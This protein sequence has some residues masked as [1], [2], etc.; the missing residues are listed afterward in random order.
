MTPHGVRQWMARLGVIGGTA[1]LLAGCPDTPDKLATPG[2]Q[3]SWDSPVAS[4]YVEPQGSFTLDR[5]PAVFD[6]SVADAFGRKEPGAGP[7]YS[8]GGT[9]Y[10]P[11]WDF[12]GFDRNSST[13]PRTPTIA[14][15]DA[16][17]MCDGCDWGFVLGDGA[18]VGAAGYHNPFLNPGYIGNLEPSTTY[19]VALFR[20]GTTINGALDASQSALGQV[21][22]APDALVPVGGT[23]KG[24]P[25][26]PIVSFPTIIPMQTD[27]NPYILGNFTS[28]A[29]GLGAFDVVVDGAGVLY[30]DVSGAPPDAAFDSSLV[31]RNDDTQTTFPRYN[32][33]VILQGPAVDAA[34]A[35][36]NPQILRIQ[37]GQDFLAG[38]GAMINNGYAPFP[39]ALPADELSQG[40]GFLGARPDS[41]T[42]VYNQ[43]E[44]LAGGAEYQPFFVNPENGGTFAPV[45][46]TYEK[47]KILAERDPITGEVIATRDSVV[48]TTT[49]VSSFVGGNQA[50]E[51]GVGYR[52]RMIISDNTLSGGASD[53]I[54]FYTHLVLTIADSPNLA[55]LPD[56]KPWFFRY[57]DQNGTPGDYS[58]D[59]FIL[60]GPTTFGSLNMADPDA[61]RAYSGEGQGASGFRED[62]FIAEMTRLSRPPVGFELVGWLVDV[63]GDEYRLENMSG[64]PPERVDLSNVDEEDIPGITTDNGVLEAYFRG[65][66]GDLSGATWY[67]PS[68]PSASCPAGEVANPDRPESGLIGSDLRLFFIT[69]E[70]KN[71]APGMGY[72]PVQSAEVPQRIVRGEPECI[73]AS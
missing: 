11:G 16:A 49:G 72:I 55:N 56:S 69:L 51:A 38:S 39:G 41:L 61:S 57:T 46:G 68:P 67:D 7:Y 18:E 5:V 64:P 9:P 33:L 53:S 31:A 66:Q 50:D 21:V 14:D 27:A 73:P 54:G 70:A 17:I 48:E 20:Y 15:D 30:S 24:D 25:T 23:P 10:G 35:A 19:I 52:H 37:M 40:P 36:D 58:D 22:D 12:T 13:D 28:N 29:S 63:N 62:E 32:Y 1:A 60:D 8:A 43:L 45:V 34:D 6:T 71:G 2:S 42:V 65:F 47:V 4:A 26:V 3:P 44:E 59:S